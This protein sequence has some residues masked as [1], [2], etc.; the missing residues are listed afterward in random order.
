[1]SDPL[2]LN[3]P[4]RRRVPSEMSESLTGESTVDMERAKCNEY[5]IMGERTICPDWAIATE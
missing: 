4:L 1:M 5:P 2:L 3:E